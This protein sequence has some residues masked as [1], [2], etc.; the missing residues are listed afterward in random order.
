[1]RGWAW[2]DKLLVTSM[3]VALVSLAANI[4]LVV[5]SVALWAEVRA[6]FGL[7]VQVRCP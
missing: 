2:T 4:A 5:W 1:M 7:M 6:L 3:G